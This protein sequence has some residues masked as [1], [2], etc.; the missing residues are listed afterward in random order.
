[1]ETSCSTKTS[2]VVCHSLGIRVARFGRIFA[3]W[4]SVYFG[5]SFENY[6]SRISFRPNFWPNFGPTP[7]HG[8]SYS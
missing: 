1:L 5:R 4:A 8:K 2:M 3:Y 6:G 7:F